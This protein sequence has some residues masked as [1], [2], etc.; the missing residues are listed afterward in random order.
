MEHCKA[1]KTGICIPSCSVSLCVNKYQQQ[2]HVSKISNRYSSCPTNPPTTRSKTLSSSAYLVLLQ[3]L[4]NH[5]E[6]VGD[7]VPL[8]GGQ[9]GLVLG[10]LGQHVLQALGQAHQAVLGVSQP[11][12]SRPC[13]LQQLC[14]HREVT[15][16]L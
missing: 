4:F 14:K 11:L 10:E 15:R 9:E 5:L 13:P 8:L 12:P 7:G 2:M 6:V 1:P 3:E 16:F